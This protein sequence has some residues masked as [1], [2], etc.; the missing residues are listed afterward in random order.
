MKNCFSLSR[1]G[2]IQKRSTQVTL[3]MKQLLHKVHLIFFT[4]FLVSP[5]IDFHGGVD[6]WNNRCQVERTPPPKKKNA[7]LLFLLFC[8][9][10]FWSCFFNVL[11]WIKHDQTYSLFGCMDSNVIVFGSV[12]L[13]HYDACSFAIQVLIMWNFMLP[14]HPRFNMKLP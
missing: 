3:M 14:W 4:H 2:S 8:S 12:P 9:L 1:L 7:A 13:Y 6:C 5:R 11:Q 10:T